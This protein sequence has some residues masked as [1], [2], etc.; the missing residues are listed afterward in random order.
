MLEKN[1]QARGK[2]P[3]FNSVVHGSFTET[4][5]LF[6]VFYLGKFLW[7]AFLLIARSSVISL[8][9]GGIWLLPFMPMKITFPADYH[10]RTSLW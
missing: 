5:E 1:P 4:K 2:K 8:D 7:L 3:S 10:H 6:P 9:I